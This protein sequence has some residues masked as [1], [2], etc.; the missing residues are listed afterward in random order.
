MPRNRS[1][2]K[3][4]SR[5]E[6]ALL[7]KEH[8]ERAPDPG[9]T[10]Q[11]LV[12]AIG[13]DRTSLVTVQRALD[14]LRSDTYEAQ[15]TC[16]GKERRWR[17]EAP[18]AMPLEAPDRDDVLA[19]LVAL[20]IL[21][22]YLEQSLLARLAKL[23]EDLDQRA[24]ER[25]SSIDLPPRKAMKSTLTFGTRTDPYVMRR[26]HA[27]CRRKTVR[28]RHASPWQPVADDVPWQE[29]EPWSLRLQDGALY[30]RA[31]VSASRMPKT[32]RLADVDD[33]DESEALTSAS[34][35]PP[36]EDPWADQTPGFGIDH[37]R[38][39]T[40]VIRFRGGVARWVAPIVWDPSQTDVWLE[41][42]ELLERTIAYRSCREFARRLAS[43]LD[44]IISV[45][46]VQLRDEVVQLVAHAARL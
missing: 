33:V 36:P 40:A 32:F 19:V 10:K 14:D 3:P 24:R 18:L 29:V 7:V 2:A 1:A 46:P 23:V 38:P 4:L 28:I 17:L 22:P 6:V 27:A 45:A 20:A 15:I 31:W 39:G 8:L 44:G 35:Q 37:D 42:G 12:D 16:S 30:M 34:R 25:G 9:L 21:E 26:L 5:K 41:H 43:L 11:E 13:P